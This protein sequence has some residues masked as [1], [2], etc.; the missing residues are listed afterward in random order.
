MVH[1]YGN[2]FKPRYFVWIHHDE[3]DGLDDMSYNSMHVD[4]YNILAPHGQIRVK[5]DVVHEI[6]NNTFRV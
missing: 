2:E 6:I 5:Q 3:R 1:L 4:E